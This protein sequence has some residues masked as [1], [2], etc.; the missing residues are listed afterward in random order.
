MLKFSKSPKA[1]GWY[2]AEGPSGATYII[3]QGEFNWFLKVNGKYV[4][5]PHQSFAL[6]KTA[7]NQKEYVA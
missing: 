2:Y 3:T 5:S 7:A 1:H 4:G 6:A